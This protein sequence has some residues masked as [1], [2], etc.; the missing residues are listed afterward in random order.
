MLSCMKH[1][2]QIFKLWRFYNYPRSLYLSYL[3]NVFAAIGPGDP[4]LQSRNLFV[5]ILKN[6]FNNKSGAIFKEYHNENPPTN[7]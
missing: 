4:G 7:Y 3:H 5:N 1:L 6:I 2:M